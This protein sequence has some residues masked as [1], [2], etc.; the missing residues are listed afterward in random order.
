MRGKSTRQQGPGEKKIDYYLSAAK[1]GDEAAREA[2]LR[3][4]S[5][6]V[7]RVAALACR[8]YLNPE[9]DDEFSVALIA[10]NEAID[11][12]SPAKNRSFLSFAEMVIRRR[13]IDYFRR[14]HYVGREVPLS[15]LQWSGEDEAE[16]VVKGS[17]ERYFLLKERVERRQEI[18]EFK[19]ALRGFG[20]TLEQLVAASPKHR[21]TRETLHEIAA[22][23]TGHRPAVE[24][25]LKKG[26]LPYKW[27]T[28]QFG[29]STKT[30][31]RHRIYLIALCLL[32]VGNFSYLGS[33]L[34]GGKAGGPNED[35]QGIALKV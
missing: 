17:Q 7:L 15:G 29:L 25:V 1:N 30:F 33:Y 31:R 5:P 24:K 6:F 27:L 12:F 28:E 16:M 4:Y 23:I 10:F 21:D 19:E 35:H 26:T 22:A 14:Q 32:R 18:E 8:R 11:S 20:I 9:T 2:L 3:D 13:I 34:Q